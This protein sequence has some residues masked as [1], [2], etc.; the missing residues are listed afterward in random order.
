MFP[1]FIEHVMHGARSAQPDAPVIPWQPKS[2]SSRRF[3]R[4]GSVL[5]RSQ[6]QA[7]VTE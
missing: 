4:P 5:R 7:P 6:Q 3:R 1:V 2:P